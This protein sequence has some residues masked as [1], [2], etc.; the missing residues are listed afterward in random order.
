MMQSPL[1]YSQ[2]VSNLEN[3][4]NFAYA[5]YGDGELFCM[6]GK[7]GH[8]CDKH[9]YFETLGK[10]LKR[11]LKE[12]TYYWGMRRDAREGLKEFLPKQYTPS[13]NS[14]FVDASKQERL[15]SFFKAIEGR[16]V[17]L[18]AP[19]H[20]ELDNEHHITIS[21][22]NCWLDYSHIWTHCNALI[23]PD[24]VM[25]ICAGMATPVLIH[26]MYP[27]LTQATYIDM[28]SVLDPYYGKIS[29]GYQRAMAW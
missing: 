10:N 17:I 14:L 2:I 3:G 19:P 1:T 16:N 4:I 7:E 12:Q 13:E 26:D 8:N 27:I 6:Q 29:R 28:G 22:E 11:S 9:Q 5:R 20:I 15:K 25:I 18:V 24:D 21:E 23:K